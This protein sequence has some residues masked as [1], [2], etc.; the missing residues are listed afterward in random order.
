[1]NIEQTTMM[2]CKLLA[3]P[4]LCRPSSKERPSKKNCSVEPDTA[5]ATAIA[6]EKVIVRYAAAANHS[7]A[8]R[9]T[10]G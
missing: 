2:I 9:G 7:A 3:V 10:I 5:I 1:M 8:L 4:K 6:I